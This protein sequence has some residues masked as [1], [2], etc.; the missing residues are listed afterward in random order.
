MVLVDRAL[1]SEGCIAHLFYLPELASQRLTLRG[2][3]VIGHPM[4]LKERGRQVVL[5]KMPHRVD[6]I[7]K[8]ALLGGIAQIAV[9]ICSLQYPELD[10]KAL[11]Y[12]IC[13][14]AFDMHSP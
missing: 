8:C 11:F 4:C 12:L 10:K 1:G 9:G 2:L 7:R 6:T 5:R 14:M 3:Q 13:G